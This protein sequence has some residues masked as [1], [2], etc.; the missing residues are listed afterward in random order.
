M[1]TVLSSGQV[2]VVLDCNL[3]AMI[4]AACCSDRLHLGSHK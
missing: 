4:S 1:P 2:P 3:T